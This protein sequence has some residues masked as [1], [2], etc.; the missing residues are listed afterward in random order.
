MRISLPCLLSLLVKL[1]WW[2]HA[3]LSMLEPFRAELKVHSLMIGRAMFSFLWCSGCQ[4]FPSEW[5]LKSYCGK[6]I[7]FTGM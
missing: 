1:G 7:C 5:Y 6:E 2:S 4:G 3:E